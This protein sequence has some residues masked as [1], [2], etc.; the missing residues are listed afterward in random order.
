[1]KTMSDFITMLENFADLEASIIRATKINKVLKAI[2]KLNSI[3]RE[4]EFQFKKR[5]QMLLDKWSKLLTGDAS[6]SASA[7]TNGVNGS[8]DA[9]GSLKRSSSHG[10][11][12]GASG[13]SKKPEGKTPSGTKQASG[14]AKAKAVASEKDEA[15][16]DLDPKSGS[17]AVSA[18]PSPRGEG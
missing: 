16:E 3:P 17:E 5:S 6:A 14:E 10:T 2:L 7:A 18:P 4:D 12:E 15:G 11:A 13:D 8:T 9:A 1:M